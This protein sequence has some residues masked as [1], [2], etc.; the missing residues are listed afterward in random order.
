METKELLQYIGGKIKLL[1]N[2][3]GMN[4]EELGQA[5]GLSKQ[6]ISKYEAGFRDPGQDNLFK[7]AEIFNVNIDYFFPT[8]KDHDNY[9]QI[10]NKDIRMIARAGELMSKEDAEKLRKVA[11]EIFPEYFNK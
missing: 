1:R 9:V 5:L 11:E 8:L 3:K 4:Q 2:D 6:A 7:M 10:N